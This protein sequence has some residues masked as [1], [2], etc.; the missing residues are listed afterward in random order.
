MVIHGKNTEIKKEGCVVL[1]TIQV[2]PSLKILS[3]NVIKDDLMI[4]TKY[5]RN[6]VVNSN[7]DY[8]FETTGKTHGFW[9]DPVYSSNLET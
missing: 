6:R 3:E 5:L 2:K 9:F 1:A 8:H 7:K 4:A